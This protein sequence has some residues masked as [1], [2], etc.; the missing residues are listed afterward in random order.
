VV[1]TVSDERGI[2]LANAVNALSTKRDSGDNR[3]E[4]IIAAYVEAAGGAV[5]KRPS[6]SIDNTSTTIV[7]AAAV[8]VVLPSQITRGGSAPPTVGSFFTVAVMVAIG[9]AGAVAAA[10][11]IGGASTLVRRYA[12]R[13]AALRIAPSNDIEKS[14]HDNAGDEEEQDD[15]TAHVASVES[16]PLRGLNLAARPPFLLPMDEEEVIPRDAV[17]AALSASPFVVVLPQTTALKAVGDEDSLTVITN[18][19]LQ[20]ALKVKKRLPIP[21]AAF[22]ARARKP[23]V[24]RSIEES[25]RQRIL[26][27][28]SPEELSELRKKTLAAQW[29]NTQAGGTKIGTPLGM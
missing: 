27:R 29:K 26:A 16:A 10:L 14:L 3:T 13:R 28:K 19:A 17:S 12:A 11:L 6:V 4:R 22:D 18:A 1:G 25:T 5:R 15:V 23:D 7:I 21:Q 2:A 8:R 20:G 9:I 24:R